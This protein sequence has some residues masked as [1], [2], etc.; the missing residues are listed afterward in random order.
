MEK[1]LKPPDLNRLLN[2]LVAWPAVARI[3]GIDE[4][5]KLVLSAYY[6][7]P[8]LKYLDFRDCQLEE[9]NEKY[10]EVR[11]QVLTVIE[12]M[13]LLD[14][15]EFDLLARCRLNRTD[16]PPPTL[17]DAIKGVA[18][19][20]QKFNKACKLH[21]FQTRGNQSADGYQLQAIVAPPTS[22]YFSL[23]RNRREKVQLIT[24][25]KQYH[26]LTRLLQV[27]MGESAATAVEIDA[28]FNRVKMILHGKGDEEGSISSYTHGNKNIGGDSKL[29]QILK[30]TNV[31]K[32]VMSAAL[33]AAKHNLRQL[34][35]LMKA[36][37]KLEKATNQWHQGT[38]R[39]TM[40]NEKGLFILHI[41]MTPA[42]YMR[43]KLAPKQCGQIIDFVAC[44]I[45][46]EEKELVDDVINSLR[47]KSEAVY[48][49]DSELA[50]EDRRDFVRWCADQV[51]SEVR[52]KSRAS[53]LSFGSSEGQLAPDTSDLANH[54]RG[55]HTHD[56]DSDSAEEFYD[57][58][59]SG[60]AFHKAQKPGNSKESKGDTRGLVEEPEDIE[61]ID[62]GELNALKV[63]GNNK[64][65]AVG[66]EEEMKKLERAG[67]EAFAAAQQ[68]L[69]NPV[70]A[71]SEKSWGIFAPL[72]GEMVL[73][74]FPDIKMSGMLRFDM[75]MQKVRAPFMLVC[76]SVQQWKSSRD[77][78]LEACKS[79]A[80]AEGRTAPSTLKHA[81][82]VLKDSLQA[83]LVQQG[84]G[85]SP[86]A[87]SGLVDVEAF[88]SSDEFDTL[89]HRDQPM[90]SEECAIV[91]AKWADK[92]EIIL[93]GKRV[94]LS[95][96][97]RAALAALAMLLLSIEYH[98]GLSVKQVLCRT[99]Q[100]QMKKAFDELKA[101]L[102]SKVKGASKEAA[103]E[104]FGLSE[105]F[106][107][108]FMKIETT[109]TEELQECFEH[110]RAKFAQ[111][112][113]IPDLENCLN[114]FGGELAAV[115]KPSAVGQNIIG[116][117]QVSVDQIQA[118]KMEL[119]KEKELQAD[120]NS[121]NLE[122]LQYLEQKLPNAN[123]LHPLEKV[124]LTSPL[125][126]ACMPV[127]SMLLP[128]NYMTHFMVDL[129]K[130]GEGAAKLMASMVGQILHPVMKALTLKTVGN[131]LSSIAISAAKGILMDLVSMAAGPV[132]ALGLI[133]KGFKAAKMTY[134]LVNNGVKMKRKLQSMWLQ[135]KLQKKLVNKSKARVR[136][137]TKELE[138]LA[139][140]TP[141]MK[142]ILEKDHDD[143]VRF[144]KDVLPK[145]S[146]IERKISSSLD[147]TTFNDLVPTAS[148]LIR[149]PFA[150]G[151]EE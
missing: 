23:R 36:W 70:K 52:G 85:T 56:D 104:A 5:E 133:R 140:A 114:K 144:V 137:A 27:M 147:H 39:K 62:L 45:L 11:E 64:M 3:A 29:T 135:R 7:H 124:K 123:I 58:D 146:Q 67:E 24:L 102:K 112:E 148:I 84:L 113:G 32:A 40:K 88:D 125:Q 145:L 48:T 127:T 68:T 12:N 129:S 30:A 150:L 2:R 82:L 44:S 16:A 103:K 21:V 149:V 75:V 47:S 15:Q 79:L 117:L 90:S 76:K 80:K 130:T 121:L 18:L 95:S 96:S 118:L 1:V 107:A 116:Q 91:R 51:E 138:E 66:L 6:P 71:F 46:H 37:S 110:C 143:I 50:G 33:E 141:R 94:A 120:I 115:L 43:T 49:A 55:L 17:P 60:N 89:V 57:D 4:D 93:G 41:D 38:L 72:F 131:I 119:P 34:K 14:R 26:E 74:E 122:A 10:F 77:S 19:A 61:E 31:D 142:K 22:S 87:W 134:K 126:C 108:D 63:N 35:G 86:T 81:L 100:Q 98:G 83:H 92:C 13:A 111:L 54:A 25:P 101:R 105:E 151:K 97:S 109:T 59:D 28:N 42:E 99:A 65:I 8:L 53:A 136:A 132:M 9:L 78:F 106:E 73:D 20:V 69:S 128:P 139:R